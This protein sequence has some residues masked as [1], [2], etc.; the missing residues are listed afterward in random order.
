M[1]DVVAHGGF[2]EPEQGCDLACRNP[3]REQFQYLSL[4]PA[5][6]RSGRICAPVR[7]SGAALRCHLGL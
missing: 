5:Q 3:A 2:G 6:D 7:E 1:A 4:P